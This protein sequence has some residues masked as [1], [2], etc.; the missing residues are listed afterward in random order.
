MSLN[1]FNLI[2]ENQKKKKMNVMSRKKCWNR[3][4]MVFYWTVD[5]IICISNLVPGGLK[6]FTRSLALGRGDKRCQFYPVSFL[7]L[8]HWLLLPSVPS[9]LGMLLL[10]LYRLS[11]N[12]FGFLGFAINWVC[13]F[14]RL[15]FVEDSGRLRGLYLCMETKEFW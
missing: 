6:L 4:W 5:Y 3:K 15:D 9:L 14:I 8:L 2:E 12:Q 10:L 11:Y 13:K 1:S 7:C